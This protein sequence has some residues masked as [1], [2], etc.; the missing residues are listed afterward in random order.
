MEEDKKLIE[1]NID[2]ESS[3]NLYDLIKDQYNQ[4]LKIVPI[5]DDVKV[6]LSQ[7]NNEIIMNFSVKLTDGTTKLF[8]G[9]RVQHS[10][11]LGPYKGG[12]RFH[13]NVYLDECKALAF[14]MTLKCSLQ[15]LPL[16]GAK[17]GITIN[18][19]DYNREDLKRISK[20]FSKA[21]YRYIGSDID[22]PAP[23]LGTNDQI[24][25]WMTHAYNIQGLQSH[26]FS[27]E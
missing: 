18:P 24:M 14:W 13:H 2:D 26:W 5:S 23:D 3:L 15:N 20:E 16:G 25:D 19:I 27:W 12:L 4:S 17:G 10:D 6:V 22:I 1:E 7:P 8:K 21:L 11:L 9:Y